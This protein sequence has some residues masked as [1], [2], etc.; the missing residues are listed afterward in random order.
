MSYIISKPVAFFLPTKATVINHFATRS[1]FLA[2][3]CSHKVKQIIDEDEKRKWNA[4]KSMK[5]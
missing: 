1:S 5:T 2:Y 4:N 3:Q